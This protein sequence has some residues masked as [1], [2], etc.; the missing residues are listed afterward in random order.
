MNSGNVS[1]RCHMEAGRGARG[2]VIREKIVNFVAFW[3]SDHCAKASAAA[4]TRA[5]KTLAYNSK[6]QMR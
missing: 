1:A 4:I 2:W 3:E 5:E 6:K